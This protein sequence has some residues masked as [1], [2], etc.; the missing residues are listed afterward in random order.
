MPGLTLDGRPPFV[1]RERELAALWARLALAR[2]L[3]AYAAALLARRGREDATHARELLEQALAIYDGLGMALDAA[4]RLARP[5][6]V[7]EREVEVLRLMAAGKSNR[8]IAE[9]LVLS[10]RTVERHATNLCGKIDAR[11]RAEATAYAF[12][13]GLV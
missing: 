12:T 4:L 11:G 6:G 9:E 1:G 10:V 7:T 3:E 13:R 2:T 5:A 8:T